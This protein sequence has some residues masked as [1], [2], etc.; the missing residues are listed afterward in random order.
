MKAFVNCP[1]SHLLQYRL[2]TESLLKETPTDSED[3]QRISQLLEL[4][5]SLKKE[6]EPGVA[7]AEQKVEVWRYNSNLVFKSGEEVVRAPLAAKRLGR[8]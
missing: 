6:T 4:I 8:C 3:W 5:D 1:T 2:L 7:S